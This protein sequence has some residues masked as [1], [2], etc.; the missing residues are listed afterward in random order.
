MRTIFED[1]C[2]ELGGYPQPITPVPADKRAQSKAWRLTNRVATAL[3]GDDP[4]TINGVTVYP[5][6]YGEEVK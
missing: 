6:G 2:E 4:I 3:T 1:L 5:I